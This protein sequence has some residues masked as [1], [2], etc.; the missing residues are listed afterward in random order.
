MSERLADDRQTGEA[1]PSR[2]KR[3]GP[4]P[5]ALHL[6]AV[7]GS[8]LSSSAALPLLRS[9][10][11]PWTPAL[12]DRAA[13][14]RAEMSRADRRQD[15]RTQGRAA[16][17]GD[18]LTGEVD[19]EVRRR[20]DTVL[21][22]IERYRSHPYRRDLPDPPVAWAE[23]GSRLLDY[24]ERAGGR[25]ILFVPSLVNRAYILDLSRDK[26]LMRWLAAR[27]FR[28]LLLDWGRPGPLERRFTLTDYIA[29]RL[30]RA[31]DFV[32]EAAGAPVP[33]VGYCMGGLLAAALAQRRPRSLA[34]LGLMATPWDF[35]AEDAATARRVATLIQPWGPVLD[36]WG[37]LP[38]DALQAL[39]AQLDPLLALKKFSGFARMAPDSRA[40][41]A[42]VALEDWLNDG[43]PL[44]AGVARDALAGWYG[45]NDTMAGAWMV[46]GLPVD[47]GAIRVPTLA[48]IP[49]RDRI[50]PPASALALPA[51][52]PG[53]RILRPP[54][55]HIGMVVS[56]GAETGVWNPL[57]DWLAATG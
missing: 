21:T 9:G 39:F 45:R 11:L 43:V 55:G 50:V 22:G 40:A 32:V 13:A 6:T 31:L 18:R 54:L 8:L 19:R 15:G 37:E 20:I 56:A 42:F 24:G 17:P 49:E 57:S 35:H 7:L 33:V 26:S 23:G 36:R 51:A 48:L 27:G 47:P 3:Q 28:P 1:P 53:A 34:G 44:V 16:E 14:L 10:L 29:G 4:R 52:I 5:L 46:A 12:R 25:T 38:T 30:E 2:V 41:T